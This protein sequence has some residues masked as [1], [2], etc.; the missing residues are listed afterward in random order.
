MIARRTFINGLAAA[1]A[2]PLAA[3]AQ[4]PA[5]PV[6]G[7]VHSET[8]EGYAPFVQAYR[9]GLSETGFVEGRNI[10]MEFR[11]AEGRID[12]LPALAADLINRKV[13][14]IAAGGNVAGPRAAMS[15]TRSIPIVFTTATDPV[16][17][18][19]VAS[20][21]RPGG[22]VT[23][24]TLLADQLAAKEFELLHDLIP[25]A[26][27]IAVLLNPNNPAVSQ[28]M[29][30]A[31]RAAAPRLG[32]EIVIVRAGTV[33]EI[34]AAFA[35]AVGQRAAAVIMNESFFLSQ[36]EQVAAAALRCTLPV[37]APSTGAPAGVLMTYGA[38]IP[39]MYRQ[40]AIYAGRILKG[41][42]PADLPVLQPAKFKLVVNLK[43]AKAMGLAIP[44]SFLV[45]ADEVIE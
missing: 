4:R 9:Q 33:A 19:L 30:D 44:E 32:M 28:D 45:R 22:N 24:A 29:I 11:W 7:F 3:R 43:T 42:K 35:D 36:I 34:D 1:A 5:L 18:G 41:E 13:A 38:S 10:A 37:I 16:E 12:R 15:A 27:R 21:N 2:W 20:L 6:I 8:P 23:G 40:A 39:D 25:A 14:V 17:M 31:A 26:K